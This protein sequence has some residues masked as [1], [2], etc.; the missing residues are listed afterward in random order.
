M[1]ICRVQL[2]LTGFK[3]MVKKILIC[4]M[5]VSPLLC[6]AM[7]E[8]LKKLEKLSKDGRFDPRLIEAFRKELSK[9][10]EIEKTATAITDKTPQPV[11]PKKEAS[12]SDN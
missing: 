8:R 11:A 9:E 1:L 5:I 6:V 12:G 3:I 7:D 4:L 2:K 10:N